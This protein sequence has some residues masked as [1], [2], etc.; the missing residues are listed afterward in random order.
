M[1]SIFSVLGESAK[2]TF[3]GFFL[4]IDAVIYSFIGSAYQV[5]LYLSIATI[6]EQDFIQS[7]SQ[8][9]YVLI[10][11]I[12]LFIVSIIVFAIE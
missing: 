4:A 2:N 9:F 12:M 3:V 1:F 6:F 11:I 10:G 8:R 5:F 7:F